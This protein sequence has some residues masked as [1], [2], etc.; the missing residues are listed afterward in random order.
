MLGKIKQKLS[1]P[2][3][4]L[5]A[6]EPCILVLER[7]NCGQGFPTLEVRGRTRE[8][9]DGGLEVGSQDRKGHVRLVDNLASK[10]VVSD[11]PST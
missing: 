2:Q 4:P 9:W 11:S 7:R 8:G 1:S 10:H 3:L 6:S 5:L